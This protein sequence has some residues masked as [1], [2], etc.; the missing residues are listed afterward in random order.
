MTMTIPIAT[1]RIQRELPEAERVI[2]EALLAST[3]LMATMLLAR[4]ETGVDAHLGQAALL[5]LIESQ[6]A[7]VT[8][9]SDMFRVHKELLKV[10]FEVKA[11]PDEDYC[12]PSGEH[13]DTVLP[14]IAA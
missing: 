9:G 14:T 8:A 1:Q 12:P 11:V 3:R 10:G 13:L 5:R 6:K 4:Q 2:S 7:L